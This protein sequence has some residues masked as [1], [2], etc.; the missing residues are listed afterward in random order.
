[1][2]TSDLIHVKES[3]SERRVVYVVSAIDLDHDLNSKLNYSIVAG[4][5]RQLF[6]IHPL[7]G[8]SQG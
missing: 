4:N 3:M 2:N 7:I 5:G 6:Q 1:M 8:D